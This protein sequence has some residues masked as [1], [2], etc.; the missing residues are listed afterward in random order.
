MWVNWVLSMR[1]NPLSPLAWPF[2]FFRYS[3]YFALP[4]PHSWTSWKRC[5]L[6]TP[7]PNFFS[8]KFGAD[9]N[10]N[11]VSAEPF[12]NALA[13]V[14][15]V[16]H[17]PVA[18]IGSG[19]HLLDLAV[20]TGSS[21]FRV[22]ITSLSIARWAFLAKRAPYAHQC[23][24]DYGWCRQLWLSIACIPQ[25]FVA[26]AKVPEIVLF[27]KN[28]GIPTITFTANLQSKCGVALYMAYNR[29]INEIIVDADVTWVL[30]IFC[31]F[32]SPGNL[33]LPFHYI[34]WPNQAWLS[35]Q[36]ERDYFTAQFWQRSSYSKLGTTLRSRLW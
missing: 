20:V 6:N 21:V 26:A 11:H 14:Y 17:S 29:S 33:I 5:T 35:S 30:L 34:S 32:T 10:E 28:K 25:Q 27:L 4:I 18:L 22:R 19:Y 2:C 16:L 31:L 3:I 13:L 23:C 24:C 8:F 12:D 1:L 7:P 9:V 36:T 15:Q